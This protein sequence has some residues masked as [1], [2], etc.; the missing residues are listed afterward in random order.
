M[1]R[2][3]RLRC[4]ARLPLQLHFGLMVCFTPSS[5]LQWGGYTPDPHLFPFPNDTF[6]WM[7]N[8]VCQLACLSQK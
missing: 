2:P 7:H 8:E 5:I 6:D 4:I 1:A 3:L